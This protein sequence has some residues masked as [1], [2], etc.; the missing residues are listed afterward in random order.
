[1]IRGENIRIGLHRLLDDRL[2]IAF[3]HSRADFRVHDRPTA[4]IEH[5]AKEH[6]CPSNFDIGNLDVPVL[7]WSQRLLEAGSLEERFV[8]CRFISPVH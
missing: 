6:E 8:L 7:M 1:M 2:N 5:A 3:F 4:A